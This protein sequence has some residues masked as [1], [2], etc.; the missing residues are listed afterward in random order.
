MLIHIHI[1]HDECSKNAHECEHICHNSH[2][3]FY[4]SCNTGYRLAYNNK[5]CD[6]RFALQNNQYRV[7]LLTSL[8]EFSLEIDECTENTSGCNQGCVNTIGSYYC[9]CYTG[10]QINANQRVCDGE[11]FCS[12]S[13]ID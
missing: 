9:S 11:L 4:C 2:G 5:T 7:V 10:Y 1:D 13:Y 12:N 6:G 8:L 3:T